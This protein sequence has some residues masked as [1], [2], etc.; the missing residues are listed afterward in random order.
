MAAENLQHAAI[1]RLLQREATDIL[2][3]A[4]AEHTELAEAV[5]HRLRNLRPA[6]DRDR[7]DFVAAEG[8]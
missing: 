1:T 3:Q 7:I 2:R 6:I 5:D 8:F 4:G